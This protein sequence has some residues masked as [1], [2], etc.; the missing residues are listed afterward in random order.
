MNLI[1]L[2]EEK[3]IK[4]GL[5]IK[6][7]PVNLL[8]MGT[9]GPEEIKKANA[10]CIAC[11]HC[12]AICPN[13]AIDNKKSPLKDQIEL[14]DFPMLIS[15]TQAEYFLRSR[16]SIRNYK[17]EPV[18]K[19]KLTELIDIARFAPTG[20]NSQGISFIV[21]QNRQ[22]LEQALE[23]TIQMIESSPL[24]DLVGEAVQSYRED[25]Y[26]S[27]FRGAPNLIIA[28][29]DKTFPYAR[30]NA[31][32]SLTYLELYAPSLGIGSCRAG[33]FEHCIAIENSPLLKLFNIPEDKKVVGAV[34]V[35]YPKYSYKRLVDRN[36]LDATF[37]K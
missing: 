13:A 20:G 1:T 32:S 18:S 19:E 34:M 9:H 7:C 26:D 5:C 35:G 36:P 6:D 2:N 8:K 27:V 23:I 33:I 3:C 37:I 25:S 30:D 28:T 22:L 17:T 10:N 24:R 31:V 11:G 16:R 29:S 4:C 12:T 15:E 14:K 21:V